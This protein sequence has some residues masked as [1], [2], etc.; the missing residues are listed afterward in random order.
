MKRS[1]LGLNIA[2]TNVQT[3]W[4]YPYKNCLMEF[5]SCI[6]S[7]IST[8]FNK[9]PQQNRTIHKRLCILPVDNSS[10]K[11]LDMYLDTL[12]IGHKLCNM[13]SI[14]NDIPLQ[15]ELQN[16][17]TSRTSIVCVSSVPPNHLKILTV[18]KLF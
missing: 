11:L 5:I 1:M 12:I 15:R 4:Q 10:V 8:K 16:F 6:N 7:F 14:L 13:L 18:V 17:G 2:K 9:Y 3:H